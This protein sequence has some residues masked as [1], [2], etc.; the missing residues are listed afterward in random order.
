MIQA[1]VTDI[2]GT[3]SSLSF[4]KE[5][6]FPYAR[7]HMAA[8][9]RAHADEPEVAEQV[10]AVSAESGR[11]LTQEQ[12]IAQ[13]LQWIDED[14]KITPLKALQGMIWEAGYRQGD[15][16]GH[17]YVDAVEWLRRWHAQ[18]VAKTLPCR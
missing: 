16:H 9:L 6:L 18:G 11:A 2:E 5:V 14:R 15:F 13:L 7:E 17:V 3:T 4:V 8:F 12:T 10:A 1:I